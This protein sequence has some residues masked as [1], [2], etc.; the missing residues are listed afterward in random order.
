[1]IGENR[2]VTWTWARPTDPTLLDGR[3]LLDLGTGDGQTLTTLVEDG[4]IV[5]L[6]RSIQ[7]LGAARRAGIERL[8]CASSDDL[9]LRDDRIGSVLAA[10]LFHHL[11]DER[12]ARALSEIRRV[13]RPDGSLVAWW[14]EHAGRPG[15]DAPAHPR[16]FELVADAIAEAGMKATALELEFSIEPVPPTVGVLATPKG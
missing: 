8:V 16:S 2:V 6:D 14:Y 5:G 12:L 7:A 9:P 13:L 11:T 3:P 4:L 10:D 15:P 1:V